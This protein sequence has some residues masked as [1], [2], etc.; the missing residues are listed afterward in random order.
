MVI[1]SKYKINKALILKFCTLFVLI[2]V[3]EAM[4]FRYSLL[5]SKDDCTSYKSSDTSILYGYEF[6][7]NLYKPQVKDA[8][9]NIKCKNIISNELSIDLYNGLSENSNISLYITNGN[10]EQHIDTKTVRKGY[11][12]IHFYYNT[13]ENISKI[14]I[15]FKS[16]DDSNVLNIPLINVD[17]DYNILDISH[18]IRKHLSSI[19][20]VVGIA[21]V[22]SF[23]SVSISQNREK[24]ECI[25][26]ERQSNFE[27]LRIIC[28]LLLIGH[29][30]A[31]HGG[32]LSLTPGSHQ[33][34]IG[35]GLLPLG[36]MCFIAFIAISMWFLVDSTNAKF[37]RFMKTWMQVLFYSV[38]FTIISYIMGSVVRPIDFIS[39]F[40]VMTGN[41]HGFAASYLI[42]LLLLPFIIKATKGISK[43]Q[44]RYILVILFSIQVGSQ[45]LRA[46]TKYNQP[47]YSE[48]TLFILCYFISLNF[49]RWP[50]E[51][52]NNKFLW[53]GMIIGT[54]ILVYV[55]YGLAYQGIHTTLIDFVLG[56][57]GDESSIFYIFAGYS[58]F[59]IF[60]DIRIPYSRII[61]KIASLTFGVLLIHDH[62][63]F[64]HLFWSEV[65]RTQTDYYSPHMVLRITITVASI[66]VACCVI[67]YL[68][69]EFVEET[70]MRTRTYKDFCYKMDGKINETN[71]K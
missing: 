16:T 9:I 42:F 69:Q 11:K 60:K 24:N 26:V 31:V 52:L 70:I 68:R 2:L 64:R 54:W 21:L 47:V 4:I 49:K 35:R 39:C 3:T 53:F 63:F 6:N 51:D 33:Q 5:Y 62:N 67:E 8:C 57:V 59:Y 19:V 10:D 61:N 20:L 55:L 44:A 12:S 1:R 14:R 36:K 43:F 22:L 66:F 41:S 25:K 58:L 17:I 27:L 15:T 48:V 28:M 23:L 38:T 50:V 40:F 18:F 32:L 46:A 30:Y 71:S 29:H 7:D 34:N 45:I 65:V 56:T 13:M 37:S